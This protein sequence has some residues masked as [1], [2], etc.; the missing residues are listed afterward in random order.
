M[1]KFSLLILALCSIATLSA[2]KKGDMFVGGQ[3]G[4][5]TTSII[6]EG[7][8][9]T[10]VGFSIAPEYGYFIANNLRVGLTFAYAL[11]NMTHTVDVMPNI[12][13]FVRICDGFYYTPTAK[14][15]LSVSIADDIAMPGLGVGL[16]L[17]SFEFRPTPRLG[18]SLNLLSLSYAV[19][20]YED[21]DYD[22]NINTHAVN[23]N[24]G[25]TPSVGIKYYF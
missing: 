17:G 18:M 24:F 22:I 13:Y 12:S 4:I 25:I 1:K 8:S 14:L 21:P 20:S 10:S 11:D 15:G 19:L 3:L 9:A 23:F 7:E 16:S 2:Q 6:F 5:K